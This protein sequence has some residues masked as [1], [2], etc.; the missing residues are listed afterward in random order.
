MIT[1]NTLHDSGVLHIQ[2]EYFEGPF[3]FRVA[4]MLIKPSHLGPLLLSTQAN[5][6]IILLF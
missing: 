3:Y 2:K 4:L 6:L 5:P 1:L